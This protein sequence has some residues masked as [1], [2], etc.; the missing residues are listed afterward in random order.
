MQSQFSI[1]AMIQQGYYAT[2]PLIAISVI[3]IAVILERLWALGGLR[4]R[5]THAAA[6]LLDPLR[7]DDFD[8]ALKKTESRKRPFE[9]VFHALIAAAPSHDRDKLMQIDEEQRFEELL[10]LKRYIWVLATSGASATFIGL[11]GTVVGILTA[12]QSMAVMGTGGFSVVAAG[13]S[14]ALISTA[15]GLAVAIIAVIFY[16]YFSVRI[17]NLNAVMHVS[18]NHLINA[19][20]EGR[21]ANG[22]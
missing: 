18:A 3:C 12:F 6:Q 4:T 5:T 15:L 9:R 20:L 11:F 21:Q 17:D 16:N 8:Q 2:Y 14:E 1:I 10:E 13:I 7:K 19:A 22:N